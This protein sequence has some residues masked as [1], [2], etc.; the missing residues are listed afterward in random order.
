MSLY[1]LS[2]RIHHLIYRLYN[3]MLMVLL[4]FLWLQVDF[5]TWLIAGLFLFYLP[6]RQNIEAIQFENG[7]C[8]FYFTRYVLHIEIE[9]IHF[10]KW[11]WLF[12]TNHGRYFVFSD[13]LSRE[14][15]HEI[16]W[17]IHQVTGR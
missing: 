7:R 12:I 14:E 6:S 8:F 10:F 13:A 9:A 17:K 3:A 11:G 4:F 16:I 15:M 5:F 2:S 1:Q